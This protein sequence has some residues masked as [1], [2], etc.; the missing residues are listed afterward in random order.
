M[1][2]RYLVAVSLM[3]FFLGTLVMAHA[4]LAVCPDEQHYECDGISECDG[5][6]QMTFPSCLILCTI[7]DTRAQIYPAL[8]L[9]GC[10]LYDIGSRTMSGVGM[11]I[12]PDRFACTVNF[13]GK[14]MIATFSYTDTGNG[15]VSRNICRP[16]NGCCVP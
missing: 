15:C 9:M 5:V 8:P 11:S 1:K 7:S 12:T 6:V 4:V 2:K 10:E 3:F 14:S 13:K 16:C